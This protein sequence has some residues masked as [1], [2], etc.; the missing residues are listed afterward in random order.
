MSDDP[1]TP[2]PAEDVSHFPPSMAAE[3]LV[4]LSAAY[5]KSQPPKGVHEL[6]PEE[7]NA[8]L[9]TMSAEFNKGRQTTLPAPDAAVLGGDDRLPYE[10][11]VTTWP[12]Q[13]IRNKLSVV[14]ELRKIG[15]P[16]EGITRIVAGKSYSQ[17]DYDAA[18][19]WRQ[20]AESDPEVRQAILSGDRTA[21]HVLTAMSAIIALGPAEAK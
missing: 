21:R 14:D 15:I 7:A 6:S 19:R 11:E 1:N 9:A 16:D 10:A 8:R 17:A 20:R 3:R 4:A 13:N 5:N 18:I 12:E 2:P